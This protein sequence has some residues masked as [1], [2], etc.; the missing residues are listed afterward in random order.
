VLKIYLKMPHYTLWQLKSCFTRGKELERW[1][2][3]CFH[4]TNRFSSHFSCQ[5]SVYKSTVLEN[6]PYLLVPRELANTA[7]QF[8]LLSRNPPFPALLMCAR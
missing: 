4:S 3:K 7:S 6:S 5:I 2:R 8:Y 1:K